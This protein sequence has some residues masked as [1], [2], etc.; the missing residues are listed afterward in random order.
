MK[1]YFLLILLLLVTAPAALAVVKDTLVQDWTPVQTWHI[2]DAPGS[3][4]IFHRQLGTNCCD[5]SDETRVVEIHT[6]QGTV[7]TEHSSGWSPIDVTQ[8]GVPSTATA[9]RIQVKGVITAV[10][11]PD[12][13]AFARKTGSGLCPGPPGFENYP[14][15]FSWA[16][17]TGNGWVKCFAVHAAISG[18]NGVR[19]FNTVEVPLVNGKFDF[20][21][22]Y[23]RTPGTWPAGDAIAVGVWLVG[24]AE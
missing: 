6:V 13:F 2:A 4:V 1:K 11:E 24:W 7:V 9:V 16:G 3:T 18:S 15:D 22:G 20:A 14:V 8:F 19:E 5:T 23:K 10:N 21:W 12:V 17:E